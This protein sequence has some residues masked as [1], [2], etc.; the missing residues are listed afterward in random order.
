MNNYILM[1][2]L[3]LL[4][5]FNLNFKEGFDIDDINKHHI[6]LFNKKIHKYDPSLKSKF[7]HQFHKL[8][9]EIKKKIKFADSTNG[10]A[11]SK[12]RHVDKNRKISTNSQ[13][14]IIKL[15]LNS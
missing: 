1:I 3:L 2:I 6:K 8:I 10:K 7:L 9:N 12:M 11:T 5:I 4:I 13:N 15:G 14:S